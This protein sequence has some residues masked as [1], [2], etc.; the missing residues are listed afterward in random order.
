MGA[1]EN[2]SLNIFNSRLVL[3]TPETATDGDYAAIE[4]VVAHELF[5]NWTGNRVTVSDWFSLTLKEGLTVYRDQ[6]FSADMN[7]AGTQRISAVARLRGAQFPQDSGPMAHA[8]RPDSYIKAR[9]TLGM[10]AACMRARQRART[11]TATASHS[12]ADLHAC[13]NAPTPH[14]RPCRW[15]TS[16]P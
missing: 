7:S 1:M 3:A 10:R 14:T 9:V 2:K 11:R 13:T 6:E 4:S 15:I 5:H 12:R 8:I 16:I